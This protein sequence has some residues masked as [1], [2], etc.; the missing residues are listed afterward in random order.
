MI[1]GVRADLMTGADHALEKLLHLRIIRNVGTEVGTIDEEGSLRTGCIKHVEQLFGIREWTVIEGQGNGILHIAA[2]DP[3]SC[4]RLEVSTEK[5]LKIPTS[6]KGGSRLAW[7][8]SSGAAWSL[9][10]HRRDRL[11]SSCGGGVR[12]RG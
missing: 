9:S 3:L 2:I 12:L 7:G 6:G 10:R 1:V 4:T 8:G 5:G 11:A